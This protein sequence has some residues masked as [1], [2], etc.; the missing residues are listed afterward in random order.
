MGLFA[1]LVFGSEVDTWVVG[2][3]CVWYDAVA[4]GEVAAKINSPAE[5]SA[6]SSQPTSMAA[7][8]PT[9][10]TSVNLTDGGGRGPS[11]FDPADMTFRVGDTVNFEFVGE[12]AF[13]TFTVGELGI[14]V[15]VGAGEIVDF[16]FKFDAPGTYT[17][18][19]VPHQALGMV[20]T[21]TV[22]TES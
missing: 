14:D 7:H 1:G 20:G 10:A 18:V 12:S 16:E 21:I 6:V 5:T 3:S 11:A 15:D 19:C 22:T 2:H 8:V 13:H 4:L 9:V 17:L